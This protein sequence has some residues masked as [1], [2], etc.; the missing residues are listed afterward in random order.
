MEDC[1]PVDVDIVPTKIGEACHVWLPAATS[2]EANLTS[3]N[4]ERRMR[5]DRRYMDPAR[6]GD[7]GLPDSGAHRQQHGSVLREQGK[8]QIADGFKGFDW[9]TE[10][11]AFMDG[12]HQH[13]KGGEFVTYARLRAMGTNGFQEP[14]VGL[15]G[16]G[17][18]AAGT[19]TGTT[20]G[21]VATPPADPSA[22][23]EPNACTPMESSIQKT[24]RRRSCDSWRASGARQG[25]RAKEVAASC[26]QRPRQ[27]LMAECVSR[28][29]TTSSSMDSYAVPIHPDES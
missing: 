14:A 2:G 8:G 6:A 20:T 12:Y 26:E 18:V 23:S 21:L 27:H 28:F 7:A 9:K 3:M 10:E 13:E 29:R 5:F 16:V 4:G 25:R 22:L 11:D 1:S 17:A 24:A 15:E 19:S